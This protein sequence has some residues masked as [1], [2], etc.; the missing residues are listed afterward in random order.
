M[1]QYINPAIRKLLSVLGKIMFVAHLLSC[2]WFGV[3]SCVSASALELD[4]GVGVYENL[5]QNW[6]SC[7]NNGSTFSQYLASFYWVIA[8]MM[9]VGYGDVS[10]QVT[11]EQVSGV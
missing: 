10:P 11:S 8:T 7:G 1:N 3:N 9:A 4:Q 2:M 6:V 5:E